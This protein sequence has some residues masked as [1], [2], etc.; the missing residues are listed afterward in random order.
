MSLLNIHTPIIIHYRVFSPTE[1]LCGYG[2]LIFTT[3]DSTAARWSPTRHFSHLSRQLTCKLLVCELEKKSIVI[4][5]TLL[6]WNE[7]FEI[8]YLIEP[9]FFWNSYRSTIIAFR[10]FHVSL[11]QKEQNPVAIKWK[12]IQWYLYHNSVCLSVCLSVCMY[13]CMSVCLVRVLA[14]IFGT[15]E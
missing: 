10:V 1:R 12:L 14:L 9:S 13:V 3:V 5:I 7:L 15:G 8:W 2:M 11:F 4:L 6:Y